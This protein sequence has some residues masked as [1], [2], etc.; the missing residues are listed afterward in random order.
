[1][2]T[3]PLSGKASRRF[4]ETCAAGAGAVGIFALL[5][6][7]FADWRIAA[8]GRG[9]IPTAP[10]TAGLMILLSGAVFLR[11]YWPTK[12]F[13]T[14][15]AFLALFGAIGMSLLVLAQSLL[16]FELPIERWLL[17]TVEKVGDIPVG[18]MSPLTAAALFS[19]ALAFL[20]E[21]PPWGR[22]RSWRQTAAGAALAALLTSA[23]VLVSYATGAP[24]LYGS[25]TIP[26]ALLTAASIALLSCGLLF[27]G[28]SDVWPLSFL[29]MEL[30]EPFPLA[31]RRLVRAPVTAFLFLCVTIGTI[32]IFYLR[33]QLS[34]SRQAALDSL[35]AI[36]DLKVG[37]I[38]NWYHERQA[39]AAIIFNTPVTKTQA[40]QFLSGSSPASVRQ[41]LL[42]WMEMWRKQNH[43]EQMVLYDAHGLP[44]LSA[45][46]DTSATDRSRD[47]QFQAALRA[48]GVLTTDLHHDPD[49]PAAARHD[50]RLSL[51]IP[52]GVKSEANAPAEGAWL[53]QI[54]PREFLYPLVQS[55]PSAS[56]SAETLLVRRE[57]D[58]V[59][60]LNELRH[61][62]NTA[63]SLQLPINTKQGLPA[64]AAAMR[65]EGMVEGADYRDVH[66][67]AAVRGIPG[68]PWFMVAKM[69]REEIF[70]PLR[71]R[72]LITGIVLLLMFLTTALGVGHL[73]HQ[74][75]Y[76]L[77]QKQLATEQE[78]QA[79]AERVLHLNK[80]ANDIILLLDE[81]WRI[82][83]ANDRALEAYGYSL[84]ELQRMTLRNLRA[85][86][87]QSEFDRL[88]REAKTQDG[89]ILEAIHR[90]KDG[91]TFLVES[92][93]RMVEVGGKRF[94]QAIIRDITER[95]RGEE[96]LNKINEGLL[97]LGLD[98]EQNM[99]ALAALCGE[100]LK[101]DC[102]LYNRLD[103]D[104]MC[105][106]GRWNAPP[107]LPVEDSPQGHICFEVI[108]RQADRPLVIRHLQETAYAKT[109]PSVRACGLQ[110]YVGYPVR[111]GGIV[112]GS[113]CVVFTRD[114]EPT[115]G[116]LRILGILAAAVGQEEERKRAE[117]ELKQS[118]SLL[119]ATLESTADGI[120][121]VDGAGDVVDFNQQFRE[122]WR[123]PAAI[124]STRKDQQLLNFVLEQLADPA[125][126]LARVQELYAQPD[127]EDFD[128]L[129][130]K[131]GR[132]FER[133][134]R[135]QRIGDRIAGRVWSFR[136][137]TARKGVEEALQLS[138]ERLRM[139]VSASA[140]GT[141]HWDIV[142]DRLI[143]SDHCR[144][145][146]GLTADIVLSY[147][148]FLRA[149]HP[150]DREPADLAVRRALKEKTG[151][152]TEYRTVWPDGS[153]HWIT[154][155]G[156]GFYDAAGRAVRMEGTTLDITERKLLEDQLRQAQK[157]EAV[158]QLAGGVAHDY[159][160]ILTAMLIQ[161][162]LLLD[163]AHLAPETKSS[164]RELEHMAERATNLTRQLLMFSRRQVIQVKPVDLNDVLANL[165]KMLRR[166][167]GENI[168]LEFTGRTAPLWVEADAGMM[169]QVVTNL[170]LNAR[171]AM[172]PKGGRLTI[173]AHIVE[174]G[175]QAAWEKPEARPGTF[176]CLSVADTGIG[177]DA[178]T[179]QRIFEPFFTTKEI[180][181]GTG[182]GLATVYGI[183]KQHRGWIEV[184]SRVGQGSIFRVY[185][186]ALSGAPPVESESAHPE[187]K[188]GSE[189]IL[190]VE[191]E[192]LVRQMAAMS[193]R[194]H[195]YRVIE[196]TDGQEAI[197]L[198]EQHA[199]EIDLLFSDMVMPGGITGLELFRRFKQTKPALKAIVS[200]GYSLELA[201][202]NTPT[203]PDIAYLS[204]P[205]QITTLGIAVRK[206]L[207][208]TQV[209]RTGKSGAPFPAPPSA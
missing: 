157:M 21:L 171:D 194:W 158:G 162:G 118:V 176:V 48:K 148:V 112:R 2:N 121:V 154:A 18:R 91:S 79:L 205:Y 75:D 126:F 177:M 22:T 137:V 104:R 17:S 78:R 155:K 13:T 51:W 10:S 151:Y 29:K 8:L 33:H 34:D 1:M 174:L 102:A 5:S 175:A 122:M 209:E 164:L 19:T 129:H 31:L 128:A 7:V 59:V 172:T 65:Q 108:Q 195:G 88:M 170:C 70:A 46:P 47:A 63:L 184:T 168:S 131:D 182:L 11:S 24:L 110:T 179:L 124:V 189:T 116:D 72:A 62:K 40:R 3:E 45:P 86:E 160:N 114:C 109:D 42:S 206:C 30:L 153:S 95:K 50:I 23:A 53:L 69:D 66:V 167:L 98:Y 101:A 198:W 67:L 25:R 100:L 93:V 156:R 44:R 84:A 107:D 145:M 163:D 55:W 87:A 4:A 32:G 36:A 140:L 68:T 133:Y 92:S 188:R 192:P 139:A 20:F 173:D 77:L 73:W 94:H 41:E 134:S 196:A 147:D 165:L 142:N 113:L 135:P 28:G 38:A 187:I 120:L 186:P 49:A 61:R 199:K 54:D 12:S 125:G 146:F 204:K 16:G 161:L 190:L 26:M 200:S 64:V 56:P 169:E 208:Q 39:D 132:V 27:A 37:Q 60:F 202:S 181:K 193:L 144:A 106:K 166:L 159:N 183:T 81:D 103:G 185:L 35:S 130:F 138:E 58:E 96:R 97:R 99:Q 119:Q 15:A 6:W 71:E 85:G 74:Q 57:G 43:Y 149:L 141:W 178:A 127:R 80:R 123:L 207:D 150:E 14:G 197:R 152:E 9:Y 201:T 52:I 83:E 89:V 111:I 136:D 117:E 191:D 90:R 76:H 143:W 115:D 82:L 180:G 203:G 105:V